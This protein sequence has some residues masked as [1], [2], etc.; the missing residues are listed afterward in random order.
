[1]GEK[2][3]VTTAKSVRVG[4]YSIQPVSRKVSRKSLKA[5]A[6]AELGGG[7]RRC[8]PPPHE[9]KFFSVVHPLLRKILDPPMERDNIESYYGYN[10][11]SRVV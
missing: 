8:A 3:C 5:N 2:D 4:G 6:G 1:M 11:G 10:G 7:C 9:T